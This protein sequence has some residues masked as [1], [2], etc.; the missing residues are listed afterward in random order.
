V[1]A[2]NRREDEKMQVYA[3]RV[4]ELHYDLGL[5]VTSF[6]NIGISASSFLWEIVQEDNNTQEQEASDEDHQN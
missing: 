1:I 6:D 4:Q 5:K 3:H 2:K